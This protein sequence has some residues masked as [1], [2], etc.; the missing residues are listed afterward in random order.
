[1]TNDEISTRIHRLETRSKLQEVLLMCLLPATDPSRRRQV[2]VQYQQFCQGLEKRLSTESADPVA[3]SL[4][5]DQAAELYR[6]LEGALQLLE[7]HEAQKK[8]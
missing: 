2:L 6:K 7:Q 8:K 3:A 5:L 4:E 1:M